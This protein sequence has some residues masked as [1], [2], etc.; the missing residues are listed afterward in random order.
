MFCILSVFS[1]LAGALYER[2]HELGLETAVSPERAHERLKAEELRENHRVVT[3]AFGQMRSGSHVKAWQ[4]LDAW[5]TAR[6]TRRRTTAG[7]APASPLG[8][9]R[10]T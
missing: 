5:L 4:Q 1:V 8:E 10:A 7:Y 3:E 6:A 2:R 9:T